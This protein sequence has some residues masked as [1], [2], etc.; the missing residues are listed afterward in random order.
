[1]VRPNSGEAGSGLGPNHGRRQSPGTVATG[2]TTVD[3]DRSVGRTVAMAV[4]V[5]Q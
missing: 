5:A 1:V 2:Q 3:P 4:N